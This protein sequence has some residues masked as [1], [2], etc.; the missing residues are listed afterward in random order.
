MTSGV[1]SD[2]KFLLWLSGLKTRHSVRMWHGSLASLRGL[3]IQRCELWCRSQ[4]QL[5]SG[6]AKAV[7]QPGRCS[8]YSTPSLGT[9]M[10]RRCGCKKKEE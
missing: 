7:V 8:S 4:M 6:V 2:L 3:R 9:P 1:H 10:C 5:V